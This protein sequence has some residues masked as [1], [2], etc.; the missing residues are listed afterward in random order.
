MQSETQ[1][2]ETVASGCPTE[3]N[4]K[5]V[6]QEL[7]RCHHSNCHTSDCSQSSNDVN[8][9]NRNHN[10]HHNNDVIDA[11]DPINC[12]C[13]SADALEP[14]VSN[15]ADRPKQDAEYLEVVG[16]DVEDN[17]ACNDSKPSSRQVNRHDQDNNDYL[18]PVAH[19]DYLQLVAYEDNLQI[20]ACDRYTQLVSDDNYLQHVALDLR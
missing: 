4:S 11:S 14:L 9:C 15:Q 3:H 6:Y 17:G 16:L 18:Q 20:V 19:D 7:I 1:F 13:A 12:Y 8:I 10:V 2:Y 5:E